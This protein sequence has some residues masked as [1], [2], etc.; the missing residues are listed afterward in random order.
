M[1]LA[2]HAIYR[3]DPKLPNFVKPT[4]PW[5]GDLYFFIQGQDKRDC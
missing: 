3:G 2:V 4:K 1:K 5:Q